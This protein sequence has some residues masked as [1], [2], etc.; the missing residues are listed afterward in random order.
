V[1]NSRSEFLH[2]QVPARRPG[3]EGG[4]CEANVL[5]ICAAEG[6]ME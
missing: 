6:G 2:H 5:A 3:A 1:N 4:I